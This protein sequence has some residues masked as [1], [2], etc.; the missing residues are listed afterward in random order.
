MLIG[1]PPLPQAKGGSE[2][3]NKLLSGPGTALLLN[4]E[5]AGRASLETTPERGQEGHCYTKGSA[6]QSPTATRGGC[7]GAEKPRTEHMA[8][9]RTPQGKAEHS[10]FPSAP[11]HQESHFQHSLDEAEL[12][13]RPRD[14]TEEQQSNPGT[15]V[16]QRTPME[17]TV[18]MQNSTAGPTC[19]QE[20]EKR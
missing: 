1:M 4:R 10:E 19:P 6:K 8:V 16:E 13:L 15:G 3:N 20:K 5:A 11:P 9:P 7:R 2:A 12:P 14:C 18:R 17:I